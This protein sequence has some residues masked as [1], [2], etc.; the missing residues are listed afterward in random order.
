MFMVANNNLVMI[1]TSLTRRFKLTTPI[2]QAPM[3]GGG[4]T[5]A[6]VGAVS[7]AGGLGFVG[8]AHLDTAQIPRAVAAVRARTTRPFGLKLFALGQRELPHADVMLAIDAVRPFYRELDL[9]TPDTLDARDPF[10]NQLP[11]VLASGVEAFSF[12]FGKVP[13]EAIAALHDR[14][15]FVLGTATT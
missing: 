8:A 14:D 15:I 13:A 3:A 1:E 12:T 9:P 5:P 11:A 2:I 10:D 6:L 4:D 7:E